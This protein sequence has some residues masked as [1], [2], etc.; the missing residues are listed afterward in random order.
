MRKVSNDHLWG[1]LVEEIKKLEYFENDIP[2][3]T[4]IM[5]LDTLL[6]GGLVAGINQLVGESNCGK[7]TISLQVAKAYCDNGKNVL[8]IDTK[9]DITKDRL[10]KNEFNTILR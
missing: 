5:P 3:S 10:K 6:N 8:Y 2:F 1:E 9:G 4:G 7:T